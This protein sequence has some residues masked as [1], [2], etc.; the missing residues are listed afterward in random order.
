MILDQEAIDEFAPRRA[1]AF[2]S[3]CAFCPLLS[4]CSGIE[5]IY[6]KIVLRE[7]AWRK[8]QLHA[9]ILTRRQEESQVSLLHHGMSGEWPQVLR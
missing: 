9:T 2:L 1:R 6:P 3:Q 5:K 7:A 8:M 4:N